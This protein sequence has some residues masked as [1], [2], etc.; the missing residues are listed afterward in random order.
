M[1]QWGLRCRAQ[2]R[3]AAVRSKAIAWCGAVLAVLIT[4]AL[5][6]SCTRA[7]DGN[8]PLVSRSSVEGS[9]GLTL[10]QSVRNCQQRRIRGFTDH[11]VLSL[12][13]LDQ[14]DVQRFVAQLTIKSRH[15]PAKTGAGDPCLNGWNVWP[16]NTATFV[17]A[18]KELGGLKRTWVND[19]KPIE[20]LSCSSPKGDW[21]HVETWSVGDHALIKLYTDWN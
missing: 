3:K 14:K 8:V 20:M 17:P 5:A 9:H 16:E 2:L 11:G 6:A 15:P 4:L 21:L 12:F 13:E 18:N 7:S 1:S 19:T 10:P